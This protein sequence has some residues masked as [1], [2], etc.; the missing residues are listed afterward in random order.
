[1][2]SK[3]AKTLLS[4]LLLN[5]FF[6]LMC[7]MALIPIAYALSVSLNKDASLLSK[8][9]SF[10]PK[11]FTLDN[12][13]AVFIEEPI[14]L[15]FWNSISLSFMTIVLSISTAVPGAYIFSRW[16]FPGRKAIL[17]ILLLL[18][19]FPSILSMFAIYKLMSNLRLVNTKIGLII[20]YAGTMAVFALWNMKGYFD[21]IPVEIEEAAK[22][23]GAT[24]F[25]IVIKIVTPLARPSLIV[26]ATMVLN[27]VW[28][29]Y[30][31]SI[32]FLT[33]SKNETLASGLYSLQATEMSG[34]WPVF[35]AAAILVSLP[36]LII[37]FFSQKYMTSGL[38]SGGVK[39]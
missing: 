33:G 8:D 14:P 4:K 5:L 3:R 15:W 36:V 21:T 11:H 19:S 35:A 22:I 23:D 37:F 10:I 26:T 27:Y 29:E 38:T 16:R 1:M 13:K 30:I 12:Y 20:I 2:T 6:I 34:S 28:N 39:G 24:D 9:F 18:Y 25:Q 17:K 32:N 31:F 7:I